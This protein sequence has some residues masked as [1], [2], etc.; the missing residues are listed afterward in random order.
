MR[1][2]RAGVLLAFVFVLF[3]AKGFCQFDWGTRPSAV[4]PEPVEIGQEIYSLLTDDLTYSRWDLVYLLEKVSYIYEG[5]Y[6][7]KILIRRRYVYADEHAP[8]LRWVKEEI[9]RLLLG[10]DNQARLRLGPGDELI[11]ELVDESK[12]IRV[13]R[14]AEEDILS[15]TASVQE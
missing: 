3:S 14:P 12:A 8:H 1:F 6:E 5:I 13:R 2:L 7:D 15:E 9:I 10:P 4:S 11:L